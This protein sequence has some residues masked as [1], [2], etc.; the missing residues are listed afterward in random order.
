MPNLTKTI[1]LKVDVPENIQNALRER[2]E[3]QSRWMNEVM[4]LLYTDKRNWKW[5]HYGPDVD[6]GKK[7]GAIVRR[8]LKGT[9]KVNFRAMYPAFVRETPSIVSDFG[10]SARGRHAC[11]AK[12]AVAWQ[13]FLNGDTVPRPKSEKGRT[14]LPYF[15]PIV[16]FM[17]AS[18]GFK[19][20]SKDLKLILHFNNE[21]ATV[22][23]LQSTSDSHLE[24]LTPFINFIKG[25]RTPSAELHERDNQWYA[26]ISYDCTVPDTVRRPDRIMGVDLGINR[27]VAASVIDGKDDKPIWKDSICASPVLHKLK[28]NE[29]R[30]RELRSLGDRGCS[31]AKKAMKRL[32]GKHRR[33]QETFVKQS[34]TETVKLASKLKVEGIA[35]EDLSR[36]RAKR[37]KRS[38]S[39]NRRISSWPKGITKTAF[40][41]KSAEYGIKF[42]TSEKFTRR[43]SQECPSCHNID[44]KARDFK[45]HIYH[46]SKCGFTENDDITASINI[47]HRGWRYWHSPKWDESLSKPQ[48]GGKG[49][50][51]IKIGVE[52]ACPP[53]ELADGQG[54]ANAL[55]G[56]AENRTNGRESN[57][58]GLQTDG[59]SLGSTRLDPE[60]VRDGK[61][62]VHSFREG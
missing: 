45:N 54:P 11:I 23:V 57:N 19:F 12:I 51:C 60:T 20:V 47:A 25:G 37:K 3:T 6:F 8:T 49:N 62:D 4:R 36:L 53:H 13:T 56:N 5:S 22:P 46:C 61:S 17:N 39:M 28:H 24:Y 52:E 32:R 31:N 50:D 10:L 59:T 1:V 43:S 18:V 29:K 55:S 33:T 48:A 30:M 9:W 35:M 2:G 44:K 38:R 27:A 42:K 16:R 41:Y 58:I 14:A 7:Y 21:K 40:E 34:V 26:H 15:G